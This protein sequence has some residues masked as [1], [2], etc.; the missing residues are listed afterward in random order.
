VRYLFNRPDRVAV[1]AIGE[2]G[3]R[4]F[5][6]QFRQ[7]K[8]LVVAK[9][10]KQQ[11]AVFAQWVSDVFDDLGRP[12]HLPE[13]LDLEPEYEIDLT[14]GEISIGLDDDRR[15]HVVAASADEQDE[16]DV[17]LSREWA[18]ALAIAI[19]RLIEAGRPPCPLCGFPL[20]ARGHDCPRTNG[21]V[22]PRR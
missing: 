22:P 1:G 3:E 19:T 15:V 8:R 10:E 5:L 6:L 14:L 9:C 21:N 18:G 2:V 7:D 20:D 17:T 13:D 16:L 4:L 11:L 12:G